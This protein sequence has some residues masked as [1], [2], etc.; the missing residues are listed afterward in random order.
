MF[1]SSFSMV[2]TDWAKNAL[3]DHNYYKDW[4]SLK[5]NFKMP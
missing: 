4:A 3:I 2:I 1:E 5:K